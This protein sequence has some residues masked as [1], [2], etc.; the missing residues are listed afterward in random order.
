[1]YKR[2]EELKALTHLFL[3]S[4][5]LVTDQGARAV[6]GLTKLTRLY[7]DN[8]S[9]TDAGLQHLRSL[10]KLSPVWLSRRLRLTVV[11][12]LV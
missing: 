1:M 5:S 7:L 3:S 10:K 11:R 8:T 6:A 9:V 4:Y 2:Q 12:W